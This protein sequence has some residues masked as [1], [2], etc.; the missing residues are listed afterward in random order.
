MF[1]RRGLSVRIILR[2]QCALHPRQCKHV[3]FSTLQCQSLS[4][5][6]CS[7]TH[8]HES[9]CYLRRKSITTKTHS[10][11]S[12]VWDYRIGLIRLFHAFCRSFVSFRH[13]GPLHLWAPI[14][15]DQKG[16]NACKRKQHANMCHLISTRCRCNV[17]VSAVRINHK[18]ILTMCLSLPFKRIV[19]RLVP[20]WKSGEQVGTNRYEIRTLFT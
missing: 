18:S 1:S 17:C 7:S 6:R 4:P 2:K 8:E 10:K 19:S 3:L 11:I 15:Y 16:W 12:F 9:E 14:S 20:V 13:H 5:F